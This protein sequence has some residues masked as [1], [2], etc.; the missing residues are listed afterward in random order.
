MSAASKSKYF[1]GTR[2]AGSDFTATETTQ[3][4]DFAGAVQTN[5]G[6]IIIRANIGTKTGTPT[7]DID[8]YDSED[9]LVWTKRASFTQITAAGDYSKDPGVRL[10]RFVRLVLT[11]G[12]TTSYAACRIWAEYV[13]DRT[14]GTPAGNPREA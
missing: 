11:L 6:G 14:S 9:N 10:R 12:S 7:L 5:S 1:K 2:A 4:R 13:E 3:S 8:I